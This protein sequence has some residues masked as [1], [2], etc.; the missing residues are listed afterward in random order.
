MKIVLRI[1]K[2]GRKVESIFRIGLDYLRRKLLPKS[3]TNF[4]FEN[5]LKVLSCT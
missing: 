2:Y 5:V 4:E 3:R 1:K